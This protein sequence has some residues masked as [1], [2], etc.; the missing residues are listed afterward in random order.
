MI[1]ALLISIALGLGIGIQVDKYH[2]EDICKRIKKK[3]EKT[4]E[5]CEASHLE[6]LHHSFE[7]VP[8]KE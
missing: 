3:N 1:S 4:K 6:V 8:T 5:M 2:K 7:Y